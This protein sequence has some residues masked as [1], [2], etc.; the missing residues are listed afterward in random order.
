MGIWMGSWRDCWRL[1]SSPS[2]FPQLFHRPSRLTRRSFVS[3]ADSPPSLCSFPSS[4]SGSRNRAVL[5]L[6]GLHSRS[7]RCP[8]SS[9][10]PAT[11]TRRFLLESRRSHVI[12]PGFETKRTLSHRRFHSST[13]VRCPS[14]SVPAELPRPSSTIS[15]A[16]GLR[17]R[18]VVV[19]EGV[20][21]RGRGRGGKRRRGSTRLSARVVLFVILYAFLV[22][23]YISGL[24]GLF[25]LS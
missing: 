11:T 15:S 25:L 22:P 3:V 18:A 7:R 23:F 19:K 13:S 2:H 20:G 8:Y 5:H 9:I 17:R 16:S 10:L 24:M 12:L 4:S 1:V 6:N 14:T 21:G